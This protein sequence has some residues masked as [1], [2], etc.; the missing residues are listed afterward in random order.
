MKSRKALISAVAAG[1]LAVATAGTALATTDVQAQRLAG[2]D[3]YLT[4]QAI[5]NATFQGEDVTVAIVASGESYPDALAASYLAGALDGPVVLTA[6]NSLSQAAVDTLTGLNVSGVIVVGGTAAVSETVVE[7]IAA[8]G[9]EVD[10]LAGNDRYGTARAIAGAAPEEQIGSL[11]SSIGRT[12]LLASGEGFADALSG[13][14]LA[15]GSAFPLVLTPTATL[16]TQAAAA[17]NELGIEQ[18]VILGG[19]AAVSPAVEA[20]VEALG[21][22]VR[23]VAGNDRTLTATAIADVAVDELGYSVTHANLARGDDFADALAGSANAGQEIAPIL[24]TLRSDSLGTAAAS[25]FTKHDATLASI[26]VFGGSSAIDD[27][28]VNAAEL[29]AGRNP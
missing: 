11:D 17:I 8:T 27:P 9:I 12:A 18:V 24:L 25:W 2:G 5:A 14:P 28:T 7:Q 6:K 26:H 22:E 23:R 19:S 21:V 1:A 15:Y 10:R 3:R 4:S 16:S 29:A 13:G 20:Q